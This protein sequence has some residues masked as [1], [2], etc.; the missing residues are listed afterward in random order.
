MENILYIANDLGYGYGIAIISI[1]AGIKFMF[2]P[3]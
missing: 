2:G 1:T 3:I